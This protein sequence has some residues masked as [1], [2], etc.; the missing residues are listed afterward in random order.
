M[1]PDAALPEVG[2]VFE[3]PYLL[4]L[5]VAGVTAR[6]TAA[7]QAVQHFCAAQL[8]GRYTLEIIDVHQQP[9]LARSER[10][11][12]TPTLVKYAPPP[13]RRLVGGFTSD[14]RMRSALG[15]EAK[16]E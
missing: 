15:Y 11:V 10:I 5:Y 6:S 3:E 16:E 14:S 2:P 1:S 7:I 8:C 13:V 12:A 4:R 9:G